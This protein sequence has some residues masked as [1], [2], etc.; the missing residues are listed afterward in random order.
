MAIRVSSIPVLPPS[1][2]AK[3]SVSRWLI[4]AVLLLAFGLPGCKRMETQSFEYESTYFFAEHFV[5][6]E[7]VAPKSRKL[8][9][10][11]K[12]L[13]FDRRL[14]LFQHP[15][16][17]YRFSKVPTAGGELQVAPI[18]DPEAWE[19]GS[20]GVGFEISCRGPSGDWVGLLDLRLRPP[21]G[22]AAARWE[23]RSIPLGKC[24]GPKSDLVFKTTCGSSSCRADWAFWGGPKIRYPRKAQV[25]KRPLILLI[26]VDTL[27]PDRLAL[28][29][30]ERP[31]A[32]QLSR[33][34][35]DAM[36]FETAVA[37]A[38][39][40]I[41]SHA[42]LFTSTYPQVHST[43]GEQKI[44]ENLP[45]LAEVLSKGGVRTFGIVD[46]PWLSRSD[47]RRGFDIYDVGPPP[48]GTQR[49]GAFDTEQRL[50]HYLEKPSTDPLFIF[51]HI[52][53]VH[54]PYGAQKPFAGKYRSTLDP[55]A[56][57]FP[58]LAKL[59]EFGYHDYLELE[60]FSSLEDMIATY[61]E[62]IDMVDAA[63][64]RVLDFLR[65]G[66][67]YEE[68]TIIVTS[69]HGESFFDHRIWVGHGLFLSD[70]EIRIPL[71]VKLPGNRHAGARVHS[72][73]RLVD[74]AP[75]VLEAAGVKAPPSFQGRSLF[76][77][78]PVHE[79]DLPR[80]AYGSSNNTGATY[81]RTNDVKY[82]SAWGFPSQVVA[83]RHLHPKGHTRL[84]ERLDDG[85]K[86]YDLDGDPGERKNL[87]SATEWQERLQRLR[88]G[89]AEE[90]EVGELFRKLGGASEAPPLR[91]EEIERLKALGYL[92]GPD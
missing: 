1:G 35:S 13:G 89:A 77:F 12:E 2:R 28:Y 74:V 4:A 79:E 87:V 32:P 38:P 64:G 17:A 57:A 27:R 47:F 81:V 70:D 78:D 52:M 18:V 88:A 25:A 23:D 31:T 43:T 51:W 9:L 22:D 73:V 36:T 3:A 69:D 60:R 68:A 76:S 15:P 91:P 30:A 90:Q 34:A 92:G 6:A 56:T 59:K 85:E 49:R 41:P 53:D 14:A 58:P 45:T 37:P 29:G 44:P 33:L 48:P 71:V 20:D 5:E 75:L 16:S 66:G 63:V 62:S 21:E 83:S 86:L 24:S 61:D 19:K 10:G 39:W 72:M 65:Q 26:L 82:I 84:L 40:T 55:A 42:S 67:L 80:V 8:A 54:A 11:W 7:K 50:L 46:H